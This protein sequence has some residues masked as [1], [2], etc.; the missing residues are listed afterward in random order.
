MLSHN[1]CC[2][3]LSWC[4]LLSLRQLQCGL[5]LVSFHVPHYSTLLIVGR[6]SASTCSLSASSAFFPVACA[7]FSLRA[8]GERRVGWAHTPHRAGPLL[9]HM[10]PPKRAGH[11][12]APPLAVELIIVSECR[13]SVPCGAV[14]LLLSALDICCHSRTCGWLACTLCGPYVCFV[15]RDVMSVDGLA[16]CAHTLPLV[17][18]P[19]QS[20][21]T[22]G[23][24]HIDE[25]FIRRYLTSLSSS[26]H[27]PCRDDAGRSVGQWRWRW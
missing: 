2:F 11:C 20:Q 9:L 21:V 3:S 26:S 1:L 6:C 23:L 8:M 27:V 5:L 12:C 10:C 16:Q 22:D 18:F 13:I 15:P 17:A 4:C 14:L 7:S 25:L 24:V 19:A